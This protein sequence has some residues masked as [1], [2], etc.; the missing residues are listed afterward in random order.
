MIVV[1]LMLSSCTGQGSGAKAPKQTQLLVSAA[2]SLK[3]AFEDIKAD[4]EGDN[5]NVGVVYNLAASGAL[6]LQIEQGAAVDVFAS[7]GEAQM[8]VLEQKGLLMVSS[9]QPFA[10]NTAVLVVPKEGEQSINSF[11]DLTKPEIKRIA[12]G[13][14]VSVPAGEYAKQILEG[15]GVWKDIQDKIVLS[16]NVRQ[17]LT[18]VEQR[19][20]EAGIVYSTDAASSEKVRVVAKAPEGSSKPIVYPIAVIASTKSPKEAKA[21]V[22][23]ITGPKGQA[24]LAKHGFLAPE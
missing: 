6:Q 11:S 13:N 8:N 1:I 7:A 23:F 3:E 17:V 15:V 4:F 20:V 2:I 21:F 22:D 9:R 12:I 24:I 14:P 16:E 5:R 10:G 19:N 18:Y